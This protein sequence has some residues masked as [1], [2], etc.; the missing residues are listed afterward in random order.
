MM[1]QNTQD[2][3]TPSLI[4]SKQ[5]EEKKKTEGDIEKEWQNWRRRI[6]TVKKFIDK[7]LYNYIEH[8][9]RNVY[10]PLQ[11]WFHMKPNSITNKH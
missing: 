1:A 8:V 11:T 4:D 9:E 5:E 6:L 10:W 7:G 2:A 3:P